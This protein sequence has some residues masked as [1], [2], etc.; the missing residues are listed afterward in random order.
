MAGSCEGDEVGSRFA[1]VFVVAVGE[2][3]VFPCLDLAGRPEDCE[4]FPERRA[5]FPG[6]CLFFEHVEGVHRCDFWTA[7]FCKDASPSVSFKCLNILLIT[8]LDSSM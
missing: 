4:G 8:S 2:E 3:F 5:G 1:P 6:C 7:H